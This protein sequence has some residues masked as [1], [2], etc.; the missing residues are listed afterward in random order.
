MQTSRHQPPVQ[1]NGCGRARWVNCDRCHERHLNGSCIVEVV[2]RLAWGFPYAYNDSGISL[3]SHEQTSAGA[4]FGMYRGAMTTRDGFHLAP[5]GNVLRLACWM[6]CDLVRNPCS[7]RQ[8]VAIA[9]LR[10]CAVAF[11]SACEHRMLISCHFVNAVSR[12]QPRT[13]RVRR[14]HRATRSIPYPFKPFRSTVKARCPTFQ[15]RMFLYET[16]R[17]ACD[18]A[19]T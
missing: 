7:H 10:H 2:F 16:P 4:I 12:W 15:P 17:P 8:P 11:T 6:C 19:E 18:P 14:V 13:S 1:C 5:S 3:S 9:T